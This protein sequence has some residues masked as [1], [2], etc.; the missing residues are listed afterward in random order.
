MRHL[1]LSACALALAGTAVASAQID[2]TPPPVPTEAVFAPLPDWVVDNTVISPDQ[3]HYESFGGARLM[4]L[5]SQQNAHPDTPASYRRHAVYVENVTG[6]SQGATLETSFNP[7][8][9]EL[10][11]HHIRVIRDG[12]AEDRRDRAVIEFARMETDRDR[13]MFN[14]EV[15]VIARLDDVR[16][17]DVV[18]FAYTI[19]GKNPAFGEEDFGYFPLNWTLPIEQIYVAS[20]WQPGTVGTWDVW[21]GDEAEITHRSTSRSE[22]FVMEAQGRDSIDME[23]GAPS[24]VNQLPT[25]RISSFAEWD[26]VSAWGRELFELETSPEVEALADRFRSEHRDRRAQLLAALR[27]VQDEIRYLAITYGQGSYIPASPDQTLEWRYGDCKAKTV[28]MVQLARA[29]GFDADAALVSL[30]NGRGLDAFQPSPGAFDHVIVRVRDGRNVIW[31][32][33][34]QSQQ[35]GTIETM[36]QPDYG[37]ALPMD[38]RSHG[39]VSMEPAEPASEEP[40][41]VVHEIIDMTAGPGEPI[42]LQVETV[43]TGIDADIMRYQVAAAGRS[44]VQRN[45][46]DFYNRTFGEAE[47]DERV[48]IED[49]R[50]GNRLVIRENVWL[51]SPYEE[52][53]DGTFDSFTFMAHSIGALVDSASE[54]RRDFPLAVV[55]PSHVRHLVEIQLP[56]D[57]PWD[58][59]DETLEIENSAFDFRSSYRVRDGVYRLEFEM[60]SLGYQVGAEDALEVLREHEDMLNATY[61]GLEM[62]RMNRLF[63]MLMNEAQTQSGGKPPK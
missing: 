10:V 51:G 44:G 62:P 41:S 55:H 53:P 39:L 5:D 45:F 31:M 12:V 33:P 19:Q 4:L 18:D 3:T 26:D 1:V 14:G 42:T 9:H 8:F 11:I 32:D 7:A 59:P 58:L 21:G 23:T 22:T 17:G 48:E 2:R 43:Y 52:S 13:Q 61:Y 34:T 15:T 6:I 20:T 60:Q 24:W 63:E 47:F 56:A 36:I 16:V 54:R 50:D 25:L 38:G 57:R 49:D 29:L 46:L 30:F 37:W 28:L 40:T 35:G 27:F